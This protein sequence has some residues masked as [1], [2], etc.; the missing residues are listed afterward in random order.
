MS[1]LTSSWTGSA[2]MML[3]LLG[4][5]WRNT[6]SG[7]LALTT[8]LIMITVIMIMIITTCLRYSYLWCSALSRLSPVECFER[9]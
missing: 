3:T 4:T 2:S 9:N 6:S 1:A 5:V 8:Y 7:T